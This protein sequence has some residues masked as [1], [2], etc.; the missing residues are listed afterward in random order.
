[1]IAYVSRMC[2]GAAF[3]E[4]ARG[5]PA[6]RSNSMKGIAAL[7]VVA[8]ASVL[9]ACTPVPTAAPKTQPP[10]SPGP[11]TLSSTPAVQGVATRE[12]ATLTWE[13]LIND[14]AATIV[15]TE[16]PQVVDVDTS[17]D[18]RWRAE[19]LA[20]ECM[21]VSL[22]EEFVNAY[23]LLQVSDTVSGNST[24]IERQV[25]FC[26]GLGAAGLS[27]ISWSRN[28]R[29][30][31][32]TSAAEGMP[33]GCGWWMRPTARLD[34]VTWSIEDLGGGPLSPD[35]STRASWQGDELLISS[36]EQGDSSRLKPLAP[37]PNLG[38]I[39][40]SPRDPALV[41]LQ[42]ESD[43]YPWGKTYLVL[44]DLSDHSSRLLLESE[45]PSFAWVDW[46]DPGTLDLTDQ[47]DGKWTYTLATRVLEK[48]K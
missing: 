21:P 18:G 48:A 32:F 1:M 15:A 44:V 11:V 39:A 36:V 26:G 33:E 8:L 13:F 27:G 23:Q 9:G 35:G 6:P 34:T 37:A 7:A 20:Y 25:R 47:D 40:W 46:R 29:F 30:F 42:T 10:F 24:F 12:T 41:Y 31:Y 5:L 16:T 22:G 2:L 45:A 14:I 17:P 4:G 28:S 19:V 43:C 3:H 38:Q